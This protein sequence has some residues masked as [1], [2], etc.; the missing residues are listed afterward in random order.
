V[1]PIR[2]SLIEG[3]CQQGSYWI[4]GSFWLSWS[5]HFESFTVE[6]SQCENWNHLF[7]HKVSFWTAPH[8]QFRCVGQGICICG[9][10][11]F[12][13]NRIDAISEITKP[14]IT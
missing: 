1:V 4:K 13:L 9:I 7:C 6:S 8:C 3:C 14:R 2:I 11:S 10:L 12:M 5:L